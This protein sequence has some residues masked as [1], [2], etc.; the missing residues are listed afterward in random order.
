[1]FSALGVAHNS[2]ASCV[3]F[4]ARNHLAASDRRQ[5]LRTCRRRRPADPSSCRGHRNLSAWRSTNHGKRFPRQGDGHRERAATKSY[6][7]VFRLGGGGGSQNSF[8]AIWP[9]IR[10]SAASSFVGCHPFL[11]VNTSNHASGQWLEN[12]ISYSAGNADTSRPGGETVLVK[13]S[14]ALFVET[15]RRHIALLPREQAGYLAGIGDAEVDKTSVFLHRT[16][17]H[18]CTIAALANEV[19]ISRSLLP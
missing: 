10:T 15:L 7:K 6:R 13:V 3:R 1:V 17:A 18:P 14:E 16:P 8:A 5:W 2:S 9:A 4:P 11:N 12:S 19:G